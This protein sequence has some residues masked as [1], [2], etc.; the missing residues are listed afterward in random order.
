MQL[1][2]NTSVPQ[3]SQVMGQLKAL[4]FYISGVPEAP[5]RAVPPRAKMSKA[6]PITQCFTPPE[7]CLV[8]K[9]LG[10]LYMSSYIYSKWTKS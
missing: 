3:I 8:M 2:P 6:F 10:S 4:V 1:S 9:W 5:A 7:M